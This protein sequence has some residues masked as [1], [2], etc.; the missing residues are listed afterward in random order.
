M[1]LAELQAEARAPRP[2]QAQSIATALEAQVG[3]VN[4]WN[5]LVE[6]TQRQHL[7]DLEG[8]CAEEFH[9]H[10]AVEQACKTQQQQLTAV[11]AE[12]ANAKHQ[13][14]TAEQ[15]CRDTKH[16]GKE[17]E[18]KLLAEIARLQSQTDDL[19]VKNASLEHALAEAEGVSARL[20]LRNPKGDA[21]C[22]LDLEKQRQLAEIARFQAE[23]ETLRHSSREELCEERARAAGPDV[24]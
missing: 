6:S 9:K 3:V 22:D 2:Q 4:D 14:D 1:K 8:L 15:E 11:S 19:D 20:L 13:L 16:A 17:R 21:H 12:L 10:H 7:S 24:C 5:Q 18:D 23:L